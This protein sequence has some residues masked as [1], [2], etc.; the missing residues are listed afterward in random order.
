M[1]LLTVPDVH[2][3]TV[4]FES[5][6]GHEMKLFHVY[7]R[8]V[9]KGPVLLIPGSGVRASLFRAPVRTSL[10]DALVAEGYDVWLESWRACID[11][12]VDGWTL[13]QGAFH[14]H[15]KA[16]RKIVERTGR[17]DLRAI[18]HCQ[19]ST[20]FM[21]SLAAG[22]VPEVGT[23]ITNSVS[24]HPIVPDFSRLKIQ[25]L[26]RL[27]SVMRIKSVDPHWGEDAPNPIAK[28]MRLFV[29]ATHRECDNTTCR[30]V[31]FIFGAGHPALWSHNNLNPQTHYW[32]KKEFGV[33]PM[34]FFQQMR[35]SV[36]AGHLV[37]AS[38]LPGMPLE[39]GVEPPKTDARFVFFT[40]LD[41]RCFKP[42]SQEKSFEYVRDTVPVNGGRPHT[43]HR[44]DG[45]GHLDVFMGRNSA[46]DVFE[47]MVAELN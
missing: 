18:V 22:L 28:S 13:D 10:V 3:E 11:E 43:I 15:P 5:G 8:D 1:A 12:Y 35:R 24:F 46:R 47:T 40:G 27:M 26:P 23:V 42:E 9:S 37:S 20:S 14:D 30:M 2:E 7:G 17:D 36:A 21:M 38:D 29:R 45:Y 6:D 32:L 34:T 33:V 25:L 19:G 16:V 44:L 39:F 41:N 31:S 4:P